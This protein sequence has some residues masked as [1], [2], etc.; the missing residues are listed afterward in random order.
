M[1]TIA[2]PAGTFETFMQDTTRHAALPTPA[3]IEKSFAAH[4]MT[5]VGP[6]LETD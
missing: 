4:D 1:L 6:P 5:V 3:E 2:S